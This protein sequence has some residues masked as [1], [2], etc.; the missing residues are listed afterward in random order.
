MICIFTT[1]F[2]DNIVHSFDV[3]WGINKWKHT[4]QGKKIVG[5]KVVEKMKKKI[6]YMF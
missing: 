2:N 4:R 5:K 1:M 3:G 6:I